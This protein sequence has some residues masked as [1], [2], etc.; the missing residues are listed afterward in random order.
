MNIIFTVRFYDKELCIF[1]LCD[2]AQLVV[3]PVIGFGGWCA[4]FVIINGRT[5]FSS[6]LT[7]WLW[8]PR[9]S[10]LLTEDI[11]CA[12]TTAKRATA[13]ATPPAAVKRKPGPTIHSQT[14]NRC[15]SKARAL[16][17]TSLQVTSVIG[18][19]TGSKPIKWSLL[20][21]SLKSIK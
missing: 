13:S 10:V 12:I 5:M 18:I 19:W 21:R 17:K 15:T 1:V 14:G 20:L 2:K 3:Q 7:L 8:G 6:D 9:S 11:K 16:I 4:M